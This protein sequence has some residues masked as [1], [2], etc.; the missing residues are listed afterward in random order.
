MN[1]AFKTKK[2]QKILTEPGE[3]KKAYGT[4]S[5]RI[6]QR[7]DQLQAAPNLATLQSIPA[8]ECHLLSGDRKG[9]WAISISGNYR[10]IFEIDQDPI[11]KKDD[12]TTDSI[13]I[14]DIHILETTD[15]H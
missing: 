14:T 6:A 15:Y 8:L 1:I 2:L 7:M 4:M 3:I 11:P 13:L 10:M 9:E 5:K 12:G